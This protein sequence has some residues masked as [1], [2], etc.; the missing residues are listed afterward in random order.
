MINFYSRY[1]PPVDEGI[2][3]TLPTLAQQSF[4]DEVDVN[5]IVECYVQTGLLPDARGPGDFLDLVGSVTYHEALNQVLQAQDEFASLPSH[6]RAFFQNDPAAFIAFVDEGSEANLIKGAEL[7]LWT[8]KEKP[9]EAPPTQ[10]GVE[11]DSE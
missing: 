3:F 1:N 8:L 10:G 6:V 7:G 5:K 11:P 4:K 2:T 9:A